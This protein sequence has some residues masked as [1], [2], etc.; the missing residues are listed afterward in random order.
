METRTLA[1]VERLI[2]WASQTNGKRVQREFVGVS[3]E[4]VERADG[5]RFLATNGRWYIDYR[6]A[7]GPIILGYNNASVNKAVRSQV[8]KGVVFSLSSPLEYDLAKVMTETLPGIEQVRF[9]KSGNEANHAAIR[10]ARAYTGRDAIVGCGY[11][12]HG[13]W[14]S[15]GSGDMRDMGF[16]REGNGVPDVLDQHVTWL[17]YGDIHAAEALFAERGSEIAALIMV[18]YDWGANVAKDFVVRMRELTAE[19]GTVLIHDE[20]LTGFRLAYGGAREYFGVT[21]DLTTYAKAIA[22]GYPLAVFCGRED[23]MSKLDRVMITTTHAG[24]TLSLAAAIATLGE[25]RTSGIYS[26]LDAIGAHWITS[27]DSACAAHGVPARLVGL[28]MAPSLLVDAPPADA[29]RI[30][31][32]LFSE[33]LRRGVFPNDTWLLTG[34]HT[35][36]DID[37]T[38]AILYEALPVVAESLG[39][40][41]A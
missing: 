18:P 31:N 11:H 1:E 32:A 5:A 13:D 33:L 20:V 10:L 9:L 19:H 39:I 28:P 6:A 38:V 14:F 22:N 2:P 34:A 8:D 41:A 12:G 25:L 30:R 21:P 24:E 16:P 35:E 37:E 7:L 29:R 4:F 40:G 23:I 3:P 17:R 36:E 27:F 26:H 15:C